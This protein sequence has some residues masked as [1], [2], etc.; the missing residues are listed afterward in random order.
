M[1]QAK[2]STE[3]EQERQRLNELYRQRRERLAALEQEEAN[4][5]EGQGQLNIME[6][7]PVARGGFRPK[8][9]AELKVMRDAYRASYVAGKV[10]LYLLT[11]VSLVSRSPYP[12]T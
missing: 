1:Q 3:L 8:S 7:A 6:A 9:A 12:R 4:Q 2:T 11:N 10:H 5:E